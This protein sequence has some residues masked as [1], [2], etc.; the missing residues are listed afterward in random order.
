MPLHPDITDLVGPVL[1]FIGGREQRQTQTDLQESNLAFVERMS[2]SAVQRHRRDMDKAGLNPIL[3]A[4]GQASTPGAP[5]F[6]PEN[7]AEKSVASV[8]DFKRL[9]MQVKEAK[10]RIKLQDAQAGVAGATKRSIEAALPVK[11]SVG[12]T[13]QGL[14]GYFEAIMKRIGKTKTGV[15]WKDFKEKEKAR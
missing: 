10:S 5:T 7:L 14:R 8:V 9:R 1:D 6:S 4:G 12:D 15:W 3:A 13:I 2:S 11:E